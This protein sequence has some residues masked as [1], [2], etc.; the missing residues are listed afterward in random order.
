MTADLPSLGRSGV[1][2]GPALHGRVA[3]AGSARL[4][5]DRLL[6]SRMGG[7]REAVVAAVLI[8]RARPALLAVGLVG[9]L[10]R[11]GLILFTLPIVVLPTPTG[12]SNF[13]GGTALTGAGASDAL[14]HQLLRAPDTRGA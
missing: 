8:V 12:I 14:R 11:G 7:W 2:D 13:I 10:A 5:H 6:S 9:F 1:G 4:H 3:R